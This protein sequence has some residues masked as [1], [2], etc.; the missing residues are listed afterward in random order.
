MSATVRFPPSFHRNTQRIAAEIRREAVRRNSTGEAMRRYLTPYA[1]RLPK[2]VTVERV[3]FQMLRIS[4]DFC[5]AEAGELPADLRGALTEAVMSM[6]EET[7]CLYLTTLR[8]LIRH[9]RSAG[10]LDMSPEVEQ[11]RLKQELLRA[12]EERQERS[13]AQRIDELVDDISRDGL[14]AYLYAAGNRQLLDV[15]ES[16]GGVDGCGETAADLLTD[17]LERADHYA[18]Y[19]CACYGQI[20]AGKVPG[21]TPQNT[22]AGVLT[23][24]LSAGLAKGNI[25]RRFLRGEIDRETA[26]ELLDRLERALRWV[27]TICLQLAVSMAV[28]GSVLLLINFL[29]ISGGLAVAMLFLGMLLS[30]SVLLLTEPELEALGALLAELIEAAVRLPVEGGKRLAAAVQRTVAKRAR[31]KA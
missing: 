7:A 6:D 2:G 9:C 30:V 5:A 8:E 20:L 26:M 11:E 15:L 24:M 19:A 17:A 29:E 14:N 18:V 13:V 22:D 12:L 1:D 3:L 27:L 23:A 4:R 10:L 21:I 16:L 25:L 31:V 28:N